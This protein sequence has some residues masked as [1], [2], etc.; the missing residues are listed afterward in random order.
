VT[1]I[2]FAPDWP[3]RL[4][5]RVR[6]LMQPLPPAPTLPPM[7]VAPLSGI[8]L[9]VL[10]VWFTVQFVVPLRQAFFP[11][12]VG[13]TGDG[14]RFSWRMRIYSRDTTGF[15]L[16]VAATGEEWRVS[17]RN[18]LTPRQASAVLSRTD[19][20]HDF[21]RVIEADFAARGHGDV[22]VYAHIM[23]SL[24][25]RPA[26]PYIDESVDLTSVPY[27]WFGPDPWVLPLQTRVR[28]DDLPDWFPPLPLQR[29]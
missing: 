9:G 22:A 29:P 17:A 1:L 5:R 19:L 27:N 2:F 25:G 10:A 20:I 28:E 4:A 3:G 24:N 8:M 14:H 21:A 11:N 18:Y 13:W 15:F 12:N 16:V 23:K 26:Q 6:G 7:R